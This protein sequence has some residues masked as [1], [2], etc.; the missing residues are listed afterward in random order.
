MRL[1]RLIRRGS[2]LALSAALA[3]Q[4]A[5]GTILYPERHGRRSG[6]IDASV[7][8]MNGVLLLFFVVPGLVAFAIDFHTG[9][10]YLRNGD[11][12][13]I[14]HLEVNERTPKGVEALLSEELGREIRLEELE[15][16]VQTH[17]WNWETSPDTQDT[18]TIFA[19]LP[20][21]GDG[22]LR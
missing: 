8:L 6:A 5:C 22:A 4:L 21:R 7:I 15:M 16:A 10:I 13:K 11:R 2:V 20:L 1:R 9:S 14:L 17:P 18:G 3:T 19:G 12:R